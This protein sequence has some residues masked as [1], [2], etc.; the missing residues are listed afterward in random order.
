MLRPLLSAALIVRDEE[1]HLEAC[2]RTG[3]FC[4]YRPDPAAPTAWR[5]SEG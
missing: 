1:R 2:L 3:V 4:E 5:I